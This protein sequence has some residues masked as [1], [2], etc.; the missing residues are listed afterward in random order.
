MEEQE[1]KKWLI[2]MWVSAGVL[3]ITGSLAATFFIQH[4]KAMIRSSGQM[5]HV[6]QANIEN[7]PVSAS[8]YESDIY[9]DPHHV[10]AAKE[11]TASQQNES[12][13]VP[14]LPPSHFSHSNTPNLSGGDEG[15]T[16]VDSNHTDTQVQDLIVPKSTVYYNGSR[17]KKLVALTFDDGP[18]DKY[19]PEVLSILKQEN[20][21]ATFFLIGNRVT[22]FPDRVKQIASLGHAIGNHSWDHPDFNKLTASQMQ[23]ELKKT[24][25]VLYPLIGYH[26]QLFRPPYGSA[27]DSVL[28]EARAEGYA[29]IDWSV[30]SLDWKGTQPKQILNYVRQEIYPGGIILQHSA[31]GNGDT[32]ENTV[33]ALPKIISELRSSGYQFVTI[34]ELLHIPLSHDVK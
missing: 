21:H 32:L 20:I 23:M 7:V 26:T 6:D 15:Q 16:R 25:Q 12:I 29:V 13:Y 34:P 30:D 2:G 14:D 5:V 10:S 18:D 24:D 33:T 11:D 31:G 27:N 8:V 4:N 1:V 22:A 17:D 28:K 19:T 9:M 3:L